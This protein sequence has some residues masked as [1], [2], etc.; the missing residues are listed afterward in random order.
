M[1]N[2]NLDDIQSS[3]ETDQIFQKLK[4]IFQNQGNSN[5]KS[6]VEQ[7]EKESDIICNDETILTS[8]K[9]EALFN[10]KKVDHSFTIVEQN[11]TKSTTPSKDILQ[12][13]SDTDIDQVTKDLKAIFQKGSKDVP[14][15]HPIV[16]EKTKI[17]QS[18][19]IVSEE[20]NA[21]Q[22]YSTSDEVNQISKQLGS[23]TKNTPNKHEEESSSQLS[24]LSNIIS[25][26]KQ[27]WDSADSITT[28][29]N[30]VTQTDGKLIDDSVDLQEKNI[31]H[32]LPCNVTP[33]DEVND[34]L[35]KIK[36][37][38]RGK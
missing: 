1:K 2:I 22:S 24:G 3:E 21:A 27:K 23:L 15:S 16:S 25:K 30:D 14:Q 10:S 13:S 26:P 29:S 8:A 11:S 6:S 18:R 38:N 17:P 4:D 7:E 34:I 19:P 31:D 35:M 33:D 5:T 37:L 28:K 36:S 9:L 32:G 12:K 20:N